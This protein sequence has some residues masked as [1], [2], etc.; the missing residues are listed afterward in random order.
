MRGTPIYKGHGYH[1][2][3]YVNQLNIIVGI[4]YALRGFTENVI[5]MHCST[6]IQS[7][8]LYAPFPKTWYFRVF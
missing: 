5:Q 6:L 8:Y 7:I 4:L 3:L 1:G 2:Y